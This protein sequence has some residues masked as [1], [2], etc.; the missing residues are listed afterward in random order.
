M[1]M[2]GIFNHIY[3]HWGLLFPLLKEKVTWFQSFNRTCRRCGLGE[4]RLTT[5]M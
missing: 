3:L 2:Y 4:Q 5:V 1:A